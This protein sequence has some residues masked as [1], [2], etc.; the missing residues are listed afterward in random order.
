MESNALT[1]LVTNGEFLPEVL[2]LQLPDVTTIEDWAHIGDRVRMV[3]RSM[4][5][6]V[7][8]WLNFGEDHFGEEYAQYAENCGYDPGVLSTYQTV[9]RRFTP[10]QRNPGVSFTHYRLLVRFSD[11]K[12]ARW[13]DKIVEGKL[14][15]SQLRDAIAEK[16]AAGEEDESD[17]GRPKVTKITAKWAKRLPKGDRERIETYLTREGADV[18][19]SI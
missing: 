17:R 11:A 2:G 4:G 18:R 19:V 1:K 15:V 7:G 16:E 14:S 3:G 8:D 6:I 10:E 13:L 5:W 9:A 12:V